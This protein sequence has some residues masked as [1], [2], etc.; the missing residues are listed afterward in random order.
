SAGIQVGVGQRSADIS[1]LQWGNQYNGDNYDPNIQSQEVNNLNSFIYPDVSA[2]F[3]YQFINYANMNSGR[4][5]SMFEAGLAVYHA[6]RPTMKYITSGSES[7]ARRYVLYSSLRKDIAGSE[8]SLVP[9]FILLKQGSLTE[10][11]VGSMFRYRLRAPSR[12]TGFYTESALSFGLHYR[13]G[14]A[15]IPQ[16]YYEKADFS[17]G[18]AYDV[19]VSKL[20]EA[21]AYQGGFEVSIKYANLNKGLFGSRRR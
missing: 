1:K 3:Y 15:I 11:N 17:I 14:D 2:G 16:L 21:T 8:W 6:N 5:I 20:S 18:F 13:I 12:Y 19:T 9:S 10:Y 4:D 7:L